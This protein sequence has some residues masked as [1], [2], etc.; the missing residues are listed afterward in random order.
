M[1]TI[2]MLVS[3]ES[4]VARTAEIVSKFA[5]VLPANALGLPETMAW[6]RQCLPRMRR[7]HAPV[8]LFDANKP[9]ELEKAEAYGSDILRL[10][11]PSW[12]EW[13]RLLIG[14]TPSSFLSAYGP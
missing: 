2:A 8:D 14:R 3:I 10:C 11:V 12:A 6:N 7:K 4:I 13:L 5:V 9:D 1:T